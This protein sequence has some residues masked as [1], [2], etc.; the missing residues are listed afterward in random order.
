MARVNWRASNMLYPVPAAMISCADEE[1]NANIMTAAWIGTLCSD[2]VVISVSIRPNRYSYD[3]IKRT[4]EFVVNL[5]T[6]DLVYATDF[7]GVKSGRDVD[8]FEKLHL[9]KAPSKMV[10]AP[11]IGESPVSLECKV[12]EIMKLGTHDAF[13]ADVVSVAVDDKYLDEKGRFDLE[14][15][16]LIA[17]S[18][19][20]YFALGEKLGKF[21][22]SVRK[23]R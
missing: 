4:G 1:G 8:K 14:K 3:L 12:R 23:K 17:W 9:T 15:A 21:G 10:K 16:G 20:E 22:Y 11:A 6:Q 19:G 13:I 7:C 2:P 5:T 18:H